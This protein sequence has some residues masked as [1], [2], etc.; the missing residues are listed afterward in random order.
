MG[1]RD[2][3]PRSP[4]PDVLGYG[5]RDYGN[6]VGLWRMMEVTDRLGIPC[7]VSLNM[8]HW[9]H[10]QEIM[11]AMVELDRDVV[12]H[13]LHNSQYHWTLPGDGGRARIAASV[14][15]YTL[16]RGKQPRGW[17]S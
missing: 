2:P 15:T 16:I 14:E 4:H 11:A 17:I 9:E 12:C 5:Q 1:L 8:A 10:Y 7:T 13:G 3:W 6:R